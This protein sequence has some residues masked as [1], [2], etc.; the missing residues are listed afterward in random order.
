[1]CK[2]LPFLRVFSEHYNHFLLHISKL[3]ISLLTTVY[4]KPKNDA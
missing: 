4:C 1:M 2:I 3:P